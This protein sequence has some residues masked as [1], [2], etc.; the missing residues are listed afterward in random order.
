MTSPIYSHQALSSI[1]RLTVFVQLPQPLW[2]WSILPVGH[3][4][5]PWV[6]ISTQ[7][8]AAL[9]YLAYRIFM[10]ITFLLT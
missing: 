3:S 5:W 7:A 1:E 2:E 8:Q 10:L 9:G 4:F 6:D